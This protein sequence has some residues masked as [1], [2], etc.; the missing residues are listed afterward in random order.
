VQAVKN[1]LI[2]RKKRADAERERRRKIDGEENR[3][4]RKRVREKSEK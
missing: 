2:E 1:R 3:K 4:I